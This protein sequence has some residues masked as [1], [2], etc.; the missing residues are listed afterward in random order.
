MLMSLF[1]VEQSMA[2]MLE[3][4]RLTQSRRILCTVGGLGRYIG[5][6][7]GRQS[8]DSRSIVS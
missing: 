3:H 8:T 2:S 6:Y 5:R 7:I 4:M 1:Y